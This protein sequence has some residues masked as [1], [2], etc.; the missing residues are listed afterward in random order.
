MM[1]LQIRYFSCYG[2]AKGTVWFWKPFHIGFQ[3]LIDSA[4]PGKV[5]LM[6]HIENRVLETENGELLKAIETREM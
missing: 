4:I 3:I 5:S 6:R 1:P 2:N